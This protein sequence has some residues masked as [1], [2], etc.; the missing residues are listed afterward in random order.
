M[1]FL[2]FSLTRSITSR[3]FSP[4]RTTTMPAATSPLPSRSA[5]PRRIS[6]PSATSGHVP[7]EDGRPAGARAHGDL[8]QVLHPFDVAPAPDHVLRARKFEDPAF[9]VE[10]ALS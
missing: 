4:N 1:S 9:H 2:I 3:T 7:Q 5:R 10:V 6:G 8:L